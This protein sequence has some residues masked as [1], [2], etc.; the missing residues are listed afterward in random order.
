[1]CSRYTADNVGEKG[2]TMRQK[3]ACLKFEEL[4]IHASC[5]V[6]LWCLDIG[7]ALH[8]RYIFPFREVVV[9]RVFVAQCLID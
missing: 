9:I 5:A 8:S 2:R 6:M 1:M 7:E 4:Q 3:E